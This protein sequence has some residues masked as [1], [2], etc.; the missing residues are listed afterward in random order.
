MD[1]NINNNENENTINNSLDKIS[2]SVKEKEEMEIKIN[3]LSFE[4]KKEI[5]MIV[6]KN[7]EKYSENNNGTMFD[8]V[9]LKIKTLNDINKFLIYTEENTKE[10]ERT[11]QEVNN[12]KD[13]LQDEN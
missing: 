1:N 12:Y 6:I 8:L 5:L 13:D 2:F 4:S 3:K 11:E 9:G 10:V 7:N